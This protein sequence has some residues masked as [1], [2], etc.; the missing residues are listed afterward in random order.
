MR[1]W[2]ELGAP[3]SVRDTTDGEPM[4]LGPPGVASPNTCRRQGVGSA[5]IATPSLARFGSG[6]WAFM[7]PEDS[8]SWLESV[9]TV[10]GENPVAIAAKQ[11]HQQYG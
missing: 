7:E 10:P 3:E 9:G 1:L 4:D 11:D 8:F 2:E 6:G 5:A